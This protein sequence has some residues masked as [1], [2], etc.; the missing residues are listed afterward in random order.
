[1]LL[2][3]KSLRVESRQI[4]DNIQ[5]VVSLKAPLRTELPCFLVTLGILTNKTFFD[6]IAFVVLYLTTGAFTEKVLSGGLVSLSSSLLCGTGKT[7]DGR[8]LQKNYH[9]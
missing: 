7:C 1:M 2:K 4:Q 3:Q 8:I 5:E 9:P 6:A